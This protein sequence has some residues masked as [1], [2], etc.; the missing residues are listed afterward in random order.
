VEIGILGPL[1]VRAAGRI[2]AITGSRLRSLLTGWRPTLP[3]RS[4]SPS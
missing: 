3:A 4:P 1:E 2:V